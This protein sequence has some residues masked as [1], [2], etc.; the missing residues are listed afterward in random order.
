MGP[1][2]A[3][4]SP[5]SGRAVIVSASGSK[6]PTT[7]ELV[8][9]FGELRV[10]DLKTGTVSFSRAFPVRSRAS[11]VS[12]VSV[13]HDGAYAALQ[14][15]TETS[16]VDLAS[17][18]VVRTLDAFRPSAFSWDDA[19]IAVDAGPG[20]DRGEVVDIATGRVLWIDPDVGRVTQSAIGDPGGGEELMLLV[21]T[22]QLNDLV[23]VTASGADRTVATNVFTAQVGPCPSCSAF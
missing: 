20:R 21:T 16:I 3:A 19:R 6:D 8:I 18:R 12:V 14:T 2:I 23:V 15:E 17:G 13:S 5:T 11:A 9:T 22:G 4:C 7:T 1:D 10:I